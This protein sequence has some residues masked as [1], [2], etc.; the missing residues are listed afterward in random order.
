MQKCILPPLYDRN[1]DHDACGVGFIASLNREAS[2]KIIEMSLEAVLNLTHRGAVG[3]DANTGDGAGI[4]F[5]KPHEFFIKN[6]IELKSFSFDDYGVAQVFF[7]NNEKAVTECLNV[8]EKCVKE[9]GLSIVSIRSVPTNDATLGMLAKKSQPIIKQIFVTK[10]K[11]PLTE[12]RLYIL[13]RVI[14]NT[15]LNNYKDY[16]ED[17][18]ICSFSINTIVYKGMLL[19]SQIP[20]YFI[21]L[22]DPLI[23]SKFALFHQR[24]S[25]NTLPAWRLAQPFRYI[26]HN[27]EINT[28][29]GNI[30]K[31]KSREKIIKSDVFGDEIEKIFPVI[32]PGGSDSACFDNCFELLL[33]GGRSCE[34]S[35]MMMIP[36]AFGKK[37]YMSEDRRA[38]YEYYSSIMEPWDG[39]AAIVATDGKT[40]CGTLD[41]NGLRSSRYLITKDGF[42]ILASEIG[43]IDIKPENIKQLGRLQPGK[44]LS[45]NTETGK[46][47]FDNEV[48]SNI[49]RSKPYRR[50]LEKNRIE[51]TGLTT[52][53][54]IE[55]MDEKEL[56]RGQQVFGW[57]KEMIKMHV[58]SMCHDGQEPVGSMGIDVPL[59]VLSEKPQ[60]FFNYFKQLFAQV[61]NLP[62][63]PYRENLVMSLMSW[64][65]KKGNILTEEETHCAQLK[66]PHPILT[67]EDLQRII[68]SNNPYLKTKRIS[69]CID[70]GADGKK[71]EKSLEEL[72]NKA[73]ESIKEGNTILILSDKDYDKNRMPIPSL[74]ALSAIH[75]HL[76]RKGNREMCGIIVE[77]GEVIETMHFALL[78]GYGANAICPYLAFKSIVQLKENGDISN[79]ITLE[80]AIE[81]YIN[82]IKK[83]LLK[84]LSKMGISTIRSYQGAQIFEA[85][86][87]SEE[88]INKHFE[89]TASRI[90]G[91]G[92]DIISIEARERHKKGYPE[93]KEEPEPL[94]YGGVF[95]YRKDGEIHLWNPFTIAKLHEAVK[96]DSYQ[97]FKE[98]SKL[99]NEQQKNLYTLRG[100]F[101]FKESPIPIDEVEPVEN[102]YKRFATGAMSFGSI[103][104]EA[105]ESIAIAMNRIGGFSNTGEGGEDPERFKVLPNGDS[106]CSAI[107]QVASGRFGVT[108]NY[109]ANARELQIKIAQGAKPGEGGQLPGAKVDEVI[110]KTR[111]STPGVTLISPPPHHDIYSIEDIAQLIFD[112]HCV[113]TEARVSVKLVSEVGVGTVAAG[114]AKGKS[115][116]VL[117]SGYDGGT[118][119][120]PLTSIQHA[121]IPWELGLAETQQTLVANHLRDKIRVQVDGKLMTGRDVVIAAMLGAEEYGFATS[122]LITL[123]CCMLRKCHLNTCTMGIATQDIDMRRHFSGKPE[124]VVNFFKF[125]AMEIREYLA[126]LGVRSI[127]ELIG[128]TDLIEI[129]ENSYHWKSKTLDFSKILYY[130]KNP[131]VDVRCTKN[132]DRMLETSLDYTLLLD[133]VKDA[134]EK[135]TKISFEVPIRNIHRAVGTMISGKIAKIYGENGLPEDTIKIKFNG[136]AGQSFGAFLCKGVT[137]ELEGYANDYLGKGLSGGKIIVY[138]PKNADI[139]PGDNIVVGNTLL[140]GATRGEVYISGAAGE[141][142]AVRNS[143][144]K[145]VIERVGDHGCEYMT[146]GIV[147]VLGPTGR[148]F[149][150]GMSGG[151]AYVY[152]PDQL[153]DTYC[154]LELV[155]LVPVVEESDKNT[156][157]EMIT[158]HYEYTKSEKAK[159]ILDRW[160]ISIEK[161]VKVFPL[162]YKLALSRIKANEIANS[163]QIQVTEEVSNG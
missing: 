155:D 139:E 96:K 92:Y 102:I 129:D 15:I 36:E 140:Y 116:M 114:V 106:K 28:L 151:I 51:L 3:G 68:K 95:H 54:D 11:K 67:E 153:F 16:S 38:F 101:K 130:E 24:Y 90:G 163:D 110:A 86:G 126:R 10:D 111:F 48:K 142:F 82:A 104:K 89:G 71:L 8:I 66:L 53:Y 18:Y 49:I 75:H 118:G 119:A 39:P 37:Y 46:V 134:I 2:H 133:K 121:G 56:L 45:V 131:E 22:K 154:N 105:H 5:E 61:T 99:I 85:I 62:I 63:N 4:L 147:V 13:R 80:E 14:E 149:A 29:R 58:V 117:I 57:T 120:S 122:V 60:V 20:E 70:K 98:Y 9:E 127:D 132:Q 148:N 84:T 1:Y 109:L 34:H 64:L 141:R 27:G 79:D 124:Y 150:A 159:H 156:L 100:M 59:A 158:K 144:A 73:E 6:I 47:S 128:R 123:G 55:K 65:G 83:G 42:I 88:I 91:I 77:S 74:L 113:N 21:D 17:F 108:A 97:I 94:D 78:L 145:A 41:R 32:I 23:K 76:I 30:N 125:I 7:P 33:H 112:L 152:D 31:M 115:D 44:M 72:C 12:T 137:F 19:A 157:K 146:G 35:L 136:T 52:I 50:W 69:I 162:D 107:K 87:V 40:I 135:K 138:P 43:V 161:F 93:H 25:T 103:S 26:A 81:N 143:G 160:D